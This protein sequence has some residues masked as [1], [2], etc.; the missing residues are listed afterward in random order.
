MNIE[1]LNPSSAG[2]SF[3]KHTNHAYLLYYKEFMKDPDHE[4][5]FG[6]LRKFMENHYGVNNSN[7]RNMFT[8][9]KDCR[10]VKYEKGESV[11]G[12]SFFTDLGKAYAKTIDSIELLSEDLHPLENKLAYEKF[13]GIEQ[14]IICRGLHN[15][16]KTDDSS[17][18]KTLAKT[19]D[20][21]ISFHSIDRIEYALIIYFS[22]Q[23][24]DYLDKLTEV[25]EKYR[26]KQI[27]IN[28]KV[29]TRDDNS[30][31]KGERTLQEIS[32]LT[33]YTYI[34]GLLQQAGLVVKEKTR[35]EFNMNKI[36]I[37]RTMVSGDQYGTN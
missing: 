33:S 36:E 37:A 28:V 9:L 22:S 16:M 8:L 27:D 7:S 29:N 30:P 17:F 12:R 34:C 5:K 23:S 18:T 31:V 11:S 24:N 10:F 20:F 4:W 25:V 19:I 1:V 21:L 35:F 3:T 15:V 6:E 26:K 32:A 13:L 2:A 14:E